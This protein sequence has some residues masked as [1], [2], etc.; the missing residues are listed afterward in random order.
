MSVLSV[1]DP[2]QVQTTEGR[3]YQNVR[4]VLLGMHALGNDVTGLAEHITPYIVQRWAAG[5]SQDIARGTHPGQSS[6]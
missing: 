1:K 4:A 5:S 6:H 2:A 3:L